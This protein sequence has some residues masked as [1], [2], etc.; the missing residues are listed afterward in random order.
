MAE[1][2]YVAVNK[3]GKREKG[4]IEAVDEQDLKK[5]LRLKGLILVNS[6]KSTKSQRKS[7]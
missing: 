2:N 7:K 1:F 4:I 3:Q 6:I 5:K